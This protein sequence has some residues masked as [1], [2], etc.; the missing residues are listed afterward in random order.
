M[1]L[2]CFKTSVDPGVIPS[3]RPSFHDVAI[4]STRRIGFALP[5]AL[6]RRESGPFR[7][8]KNELCVVGI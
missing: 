3:V 7:M 8:W 5:P 4:P 6:S 2:R 1:Q